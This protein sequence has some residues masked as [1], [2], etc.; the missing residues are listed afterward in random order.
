MASGADSNPD[1]G[2]SAYTGLESLL[3]YQFQQPLLLKQALTHRSFSKE[4]NER[5]ELLGDSVLNLAIVR[6]LYGR[7]PAASEGELSRMLSS[8]VKGSTLADIAAELRLGE[9]LRLGVGE[10][11]SGGRRRRSI[12]A[13]TVEAVLGAVY[14]DADF[15][16]A[17]RVIQQL[18]EPRIRAIDPAGPDKDAKTRLQELLQAEQHALPEYRVVR[19]WGPAHER[20]FEVSCQIALLDKRS[21]GVG[22]SRRDAE[23]E[24]A[25]AAL[26]QLDNV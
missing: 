8:L 9:Y 17:E 18:F 23:Q 16:A 6:Q 24:A 2:S 10:S 21:T 19:S 12:L 22:N 14:L 15:T 25:R 1:S 20:Q 26:E 5:L 4:H 13:D 7:F 3:D 11:N